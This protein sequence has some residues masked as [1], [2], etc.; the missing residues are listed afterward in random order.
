[1]FIRDGTFYTYAKTH[2]FLTFS[3]FTNVSEQL[4]IADYKLKKISFLAFNGMWFDK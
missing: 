3:L 4:Q 2:F 1:M